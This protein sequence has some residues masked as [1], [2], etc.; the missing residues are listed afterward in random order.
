MNESDF[1]HEASRIL[2]DEKTH[3]KVQKLKLLFEAHEHKVLNLIARPTC[4]NHGVMEGEDEDDGTGNQPRI[5][6]H[7]QKRMN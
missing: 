1:A 7:A 5:Y 3:C 4:P 6:S 2:S